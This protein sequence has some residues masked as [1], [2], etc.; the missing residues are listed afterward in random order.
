MNVLN[1]K[2]SINSKNNSIKQRENRTPITRIA[3]CL[4]PSPDQYQNLTNKFLLNKF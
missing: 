4:T 2:L 3:N 1:R